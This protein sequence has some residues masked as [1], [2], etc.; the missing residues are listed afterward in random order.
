MGLHRQMDGQTDEYTD[1]DRQQGDLISLLFFLSKE[2]KL[3]YSIYVY[4]SNN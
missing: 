1:T 2:S 4:F 3:K